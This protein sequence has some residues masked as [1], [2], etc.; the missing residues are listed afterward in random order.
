MPTIVCVAGGARAIVPVPR[1]VDGLLPL[2]LSR[3]SEALA[4]ARAVL[5]GEPDHYESS[6]AHQAVGIVLREFGDVEAGVRELREALRLARRSGRTDREADVLATLGVGLV[7]A[8]RTAAGLIALDRAFQRSSGVLAAQVQVRRGMMLYSLGR[9]PAAL[10]DLRK[11]AIVLRRAGD[12]LWTARALNMRA[13]VHLA[14]G[15]TRRADADFAS[16][17]HL[18]T[19][20]GQELEAL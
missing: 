6:V 11:S 1:D 3:P 4:R 19:G 7:F 20:A 15:S 18:F 2:A 17:G 14:V 12:L 8:G 10:D 16:A 5:A 13:I 9:Y